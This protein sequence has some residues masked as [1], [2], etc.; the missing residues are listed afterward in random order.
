MIRNVLFSCSP[1]CVDDIMLVSVVHPIFIVQI[2]EELSITKSGFYLDPDYRVGK[3]T[4]SDWH[5]T[6]S[7]QY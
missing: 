7:T 3:R 2:R 4:S 5:E 1:R 6:K